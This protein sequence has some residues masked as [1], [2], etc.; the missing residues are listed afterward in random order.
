MSEVELLST[1]GLVLANGHPK[2]DISIGQGLTLVHS[3]RE[4]SSTMWAMTLA[5]RMKS[6]SGQIFLS[7]EPASASQLHQKIA[8]AGVV[9]L[10]SLERQVSVASIVREQVAWS[11]PWYKRAPKNIAEID[12]FMEITEL[13]G[14]DL[15]F[16]NAAKFTAGSLTPYERFKLRVALAFLSRPKAKLLVVDDIDQ[17]RSMELRATVL[18]R[19]AEVSQHI[20]VLVMSANKEDAGVCDVLITEADDVEQPHSE[21]TNNE[22]DA[23]EA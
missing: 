15:D 7:G 2:A 20:P 14:L 8:L 10:D 17:L 9:Q 4:S 12:Q 6:K 5:G 19:L 18:R 1:D 21:L 16:Q 13:L 22:L 23:K 3:G 11:S